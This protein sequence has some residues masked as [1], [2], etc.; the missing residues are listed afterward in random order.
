MGDDVKNP[1]QF[2]PGVSGNPKGRP[3]VNKFRRQLAEYESPIVQRLIDICLTEKKSDVALKAINIVCQYLY[4]KP[5][6][7]LDTELQQTVEK[8]NA[9]IRKRDTGQPVKRGPHKTLQ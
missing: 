6:D 7:S 2:K 8:V 4:G 9:I 3:T 1:G 5:R